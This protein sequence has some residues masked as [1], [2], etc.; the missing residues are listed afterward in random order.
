MTKILNIGMK[1]TEGIS[2][3]RLCRKT[4]M[5]PKIEKRLNGE[6]RLCKIE[7]YVLKYFIIFYSFRCNL[8]AHH[9]VTT[10]TIDIILFK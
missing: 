2:K 7:Q 10:I 5:Y 9:L 8:A 3:N 1:D 4:H 6:E